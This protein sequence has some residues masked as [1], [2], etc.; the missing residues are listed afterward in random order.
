M[1]IEMRRGIRENAVLKL[2]GWRLPAGCTSTWRADCVFEAVKN[3]AFKKQLG[4]TYAQ[5]MYCNL[6][7][8]GKMTRD[9]ALIRLEKDGI[10]ES[11]LHE[12]LKLCGLPEDS[13]TATDPVPR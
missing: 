9:N 4:I 3:I 10:S 5:A 13:F 12:A 11:R 6:I 8:G 1:W 2:L 7:R